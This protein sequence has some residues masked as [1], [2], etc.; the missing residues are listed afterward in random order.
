MFTFSMKVFSS[1]FAIINID[2]Y[3]PLES[4]DNS[5]SEHEEERLVNNILV[6]LT[7]HDDMGY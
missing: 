3:D 7:S 4:L 1:P 5:S 6:N 2:E